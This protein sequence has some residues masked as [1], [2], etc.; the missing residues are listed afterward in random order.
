MTERPKIV[1]DEHLKYLDNLRE[2]GVTN[3]YGAGQYL[4]AEFS[5]LSEWRNAKTVLR[6]WMESFEERTAT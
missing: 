2:S 5:E 6:Y 1:T 3:M 4:S